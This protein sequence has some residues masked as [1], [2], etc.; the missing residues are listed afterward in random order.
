[1]GGGESKYVQDQERFVREN[2]EIYKS[3]LPNNYT[4]SQIKGKLR[5]LYANTDTH[6]ENKYS[7][8]MDYEW[9]KV[10]ALVVPKYASHNEMRGERRY[11]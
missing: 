1:M 8:V 4:S 10:K 3:A 5:Q 9:N 11:R 2:V 6:K 7:Y